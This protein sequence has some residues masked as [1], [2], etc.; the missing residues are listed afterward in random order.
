MA[1][2][3][4]DEAEADLEKIWLEGALEYGVLHAERVAHRF[5]DIFKLLDEFKGIGSPYPNLPQSVSYFPVRKYPFLVFFT[6]EGEDV[7]I[8]RVFPDRMRIEDH[9]TTGSSPK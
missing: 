3:K 4:S 5:D 2:L 6:H 1:I 7:R 8:V 9:W